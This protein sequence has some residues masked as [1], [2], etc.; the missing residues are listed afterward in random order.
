MCNFETN[1]LIIAAQ[2]LKVLLIYYPC[3]PLQNVV[4]LNLFFFLNRDTGNK[5]VQ[6]HILRV[7]KG[8]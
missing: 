5:K 4:H 8:E 6:L 2:K 3:L 1:I 7:I